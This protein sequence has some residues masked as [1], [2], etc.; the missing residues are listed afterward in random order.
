MHFDVEN[1]IFPDQAGTETCG[2]WQKLH[3]YLPVWYVNMRFGDRTRIFPD[4]PDTETC[5]CS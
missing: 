4:R 2:W 5:V 1:C 3:L